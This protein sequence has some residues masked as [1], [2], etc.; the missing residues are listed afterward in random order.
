MHTFAHQK[1]SRHLPF[2][3]CAADHLFPVKEAC[4]G[5]CSYQHRK[6][7]PVHQFPTPCPGTCDTLKW[8]KVGTLTLQK[9]AIATD[10]GLFFLEKW[11][12]NT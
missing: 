11:L 12:L 5:T 6:P 3:R 10:Q 8:A 9:L 7:D 4:A 1:F 2:M